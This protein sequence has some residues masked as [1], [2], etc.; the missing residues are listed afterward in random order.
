VGGIAR[1]KQCLRA[2]AG[3]RRALEQRDRNI[4]A[5]WATEGRRARRSAGDPPQSVGSDSE[6][7][8]DMAVEFR[9]RALLLERVEVQ[10]SFAHQILVRDAAGMKHLQVHT[11]CRRVGVE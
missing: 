2:G 4:P 10:L 9:C 3:A 11:P 1:A 8:G 7:R 5:H 6:C